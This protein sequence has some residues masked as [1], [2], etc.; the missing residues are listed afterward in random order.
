VVVPLVVVDGA[1]PFAEPP[2]ELGAD[3]VLGAGMV[4][5]EVLGENDATSVCRQDDRAKFYIT[6][7]HASSPI[8]ELLRIGLTTSSSHS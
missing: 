7:I 2:L 3:F 6:I 8:P 1:F 4:G 5:G